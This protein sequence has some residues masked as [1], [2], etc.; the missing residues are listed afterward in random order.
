MPTALDYASE[1]IEFDSVSSKSNVPVSEYVEYRLQQLKFE[2]ERVEYTDGHGVAKVNVLG[3]LGSGTGG[4]AYF[5]HTDVVPALDWKF[6]EHG[7][8][9]PTVREGK[10]YGRGSTD[11]KGSIA[12][13]LA[14]VT[15]LAGRPLQAPVYLCCTADEESG[16]HGAAQ[17]QKNSQLF[18]EIVQGHSRSIVGEP[19]SLDVVHGHKG[20]CSIEVTAHGIA[21]HSSSK[22]GVNANWK[23]IPFLAAM[24]QLNEELETDPKWQNTKFNPPTMTMN[25]GINDHNPAVNITAAK[26]ICTIYFRAMPDINTDPILERIKSAAEANGLEYV[27]TFRATPFFRDPQTTFVQECLKFS[28]AS[29]SRTVAYGTDAAHFYELENCVILGP[30]NIAQAH[31]HDEWIRLEDLAQGTQVYRSMLE[32]WCLVPDGGQNPPQVALA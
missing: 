18:R 6:A 10:L 31:T 24:K 5:G 16:M 9:T 15:E 22:S 11:M 2:I 27:L 21:A 8:F 17:V 20:G 28:A 23:M 29:Q 30:G 25:L 1:L 7:P 26:S 19:T 32:S 14:A 13:M 3:K 12:C 4:M